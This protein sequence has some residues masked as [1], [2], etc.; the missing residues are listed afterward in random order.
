L[1][2][3]TE[4]HTALAINLSQ[5]QAALK[6]LSN[7]SRTG[8]TALKRQ[9]ATTTERLETGKAVAIDHARL[10]SELDRVTRVESDLLTQI[11][12]LQLRFETIQRETNRRI[13]VLTRENGTLS[14][15]CWKFDP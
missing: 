13:D 6:H 14:Q 4:K 9:L 15:V 2:V 3:E 1:D 7:Q 10:E 8:K 11:R 12:A 5:T